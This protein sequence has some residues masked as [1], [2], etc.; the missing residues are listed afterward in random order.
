MLLIKYRTMI[1]NSTAESF[2][3]LLKD[4]L[5]FLSTSQNNNLQI[6]LM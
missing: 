6:D 3:S 1:L 2:I 5:S 4:I